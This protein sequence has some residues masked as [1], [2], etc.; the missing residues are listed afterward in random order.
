[1]TTG[2]LLVH[3][4]YVGAEKPNFY[5]VP[6]DTDLPGRLR[7]ALDAVD[8]YIVYCGIFDKRLATLAS[9]IQDA[10]ETQE[11]YAKNKALFGALQDFRVKTDA[12]HPMGVRKIVYTGLFR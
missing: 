1:M 10:V 3:A 6:D 5:F 4:A 9:A 12:E 2:I 11:E 7:E 8:G